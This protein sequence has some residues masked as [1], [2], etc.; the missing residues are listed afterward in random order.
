VRPAVEEPQIDAE[1][2]Q[3]ECREADPEPERFVHEGKDTEVGDERLDVR[4]KMIE[5][6]G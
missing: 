3:H 2:Q 4:K 5:V 6:R 1:Q